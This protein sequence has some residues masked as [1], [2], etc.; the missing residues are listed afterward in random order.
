[1][2]HI[3]ATCSTHCS[4]SAGGQ[5]NECGHS[6]NFSRSETARKISCPENLCKFFRADFSGLLA[7]TRSLDQQ[8]VVTGLLAEWCETSHEEVTQFAS[9]TLMGAESAFMYA[10]SYNQNE[11]MSTDRQISVDVLSQK[12]SKDASHLMQ[13]NI[14]MPPHLCNVCSPGFH[15]SNEGWTFVFQC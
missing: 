14:S 5:G 4:T 9:S 1:M 8:R 12:N 6:G 11:F 10:C 2:H 3:V 7:R 13:Q 15:T